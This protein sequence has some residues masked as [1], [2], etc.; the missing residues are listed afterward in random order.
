M[1]INISQLI[2]GKPSADVLFKPQEQNREI[3][4]THLTGD[5]PSTN[6]LFWTRPKKEDLIF[7]VLYLSSLGCSPS[8]SRGETLSPNQPDPCQKY[9]EVAVQSNG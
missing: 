6:V 2:D 3:K 1:P 4:M 8:M 7:L 9:T 5:V